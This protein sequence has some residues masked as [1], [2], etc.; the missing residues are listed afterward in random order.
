MSQ[1]GFRAGV[2]NVKA[3]KTQQKRYKEDIYQ[4]LL[5]STTPIYASLVLTETATVVVTRT[6]TA[7]GHPKAVKIKNLRGTA[8]G[9]AGRYLI[10]KGYT[11]QGAYEEERIMLSSAVGGYGRGNVAFAK[12]TEIYQDQTTMTIG[13][14]GTVSVY[15]TDKYGLSEYCDAASDGLYVR[16]ISKVGVGVLATTF[17]TDD[18]FSKTY[19]TI[20]V[21][22]I[23]AASTLSISYLSKFQNNRQGA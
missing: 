11:G 5:A 14:Y 6:G 15:P 17:D 10:V 22:T 1:Y 7:T 23:G 12:I 13:T 4:G 20:N 3:L 9:A 21:P 16:E 19:Q 2:F 18:K 8:A